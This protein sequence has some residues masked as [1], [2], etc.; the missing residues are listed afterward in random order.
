MSFL[1]C[2]ILRCGPRHTTVWF[3]VLTQYVRSQTGWAFAQHE[4]DPS[5][6][7][8]FPEVRASRV[9][10]CRTV[11]DTTCLHARHTSRWHLKKQ[12]KKS[13]LRI[14]SVVATLMLFWALVRV[15]GF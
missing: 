13:L 1:P 2:R 6:A 10:T 5:N 4:T 11:T 8:F 3:L 7:G 15:E 14:M 9:C 12:S